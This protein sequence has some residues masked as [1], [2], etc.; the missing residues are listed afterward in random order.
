MQD[1]SLSF[2]ERN[3]TC[4]SGSLTT[5]RGLVCQCRKFWFRL[6]LPILFY[7]L[8]KVMAPSSVVSTGSLN[9]QTYVEEGQTT[10]GYPTFG[11]R[12]FR[13]AYSN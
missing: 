6:S 13:G 8:V 7:F 5:A 9:R 11:V 1:I 10:N 12:H 3:T 2:A 4:R